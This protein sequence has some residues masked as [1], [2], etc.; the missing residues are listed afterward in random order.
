MA[1]LIVWLLFGLLAAR[2]VG[3]PGS[4]EG[5]EFAVFLGVVCA[6]ISAGSLGIWLVRK[7]RL[8]QPVRLFLLAVVCLA[9]VAAASWWAR[10]G[11]TDVRWIGTGLR[12]AV[13]AAAFFLLSFAA[14]VLAILL[15][16]YALVM[17][18]VERSRER[19]LRRQRA[20]R[21]DRLGMP[22]EPPMGPPDPPMD[23]PKPP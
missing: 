19:K 10:Q 18:Q 15:A 2:Q 9:G 21:V 16:I 17:R 13:A 4:I 11:D 14:S 20:A 5:A 3:D 8:V 12:V 6:A 1:W 22:I 7:A 23:R